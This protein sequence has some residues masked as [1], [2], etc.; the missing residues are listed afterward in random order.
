MT[1][2]SVSRR[3]FVKSAAGCAAAA[4]GLA[5]AAPGMA[6]A[7]ES[8]ELVAS[9]V[10]EAQVVIIGAGISGLSAAVQCAQNGLGTL[11]LERAETTGGNGLYA[12]GIFA[13]G[14][15]P[16][17]ESGVEFDTGALIRSVMKDAQNRVDGS[18]WTDLLEATPANYDWMVEN[19]V[20][21]DGLTNEYIPIPDPTMLWFKDSLAGVGYVPAMEETARSN[22]AEF[23]F[24]ARAEQLIMQDGKAV[25]VYA[26]LA[27]DS[28]LQVNAD[29]V[30]IA[31]GG[32]AE[33][34][35]LYK[36]AGWNVEH[37]LYT[38]LPGH[39]GDGY[40][41]AIAAGARSAI[42]DTASMNRLH[43]DG[44]PFYGT[45]TMGLTFGG[46][47]L[48]VNSYGRRF[49]D[50][51]FSA[52]NATSL[53][54]AVNSTKALWSI[55][56]QKIVNMA[57]NVD[58]LADVGE[59]TADPRDEIAAAIEACPSNNIFT[60]DTFEELA[61]KCGLPADTLLA[62]I[63][64][65]NALCA[66][67]NDDQFGKDPSMMI[68]IDEPPYYIYRLDITYI[69]SIGALDTDHNMQVV[70]TDGDPIDGLYAIGVDGVRLYRN[71]YPFIGLVG[72][73]TCVAH[74]VNSGRVAANNIASQLA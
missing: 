65:Y 48:W 49:I 73:G 13:V 45:A 64:S 54:F 74:C 14:S 5:L 59:I 29:A 6:L 46:P 60:A 18:L 66:A 67:G 28:I 24:G 2:N 12:N 72:G 15:T 8:A 10:K 37:A 11:V 3:S 20:T 51:N 42:K 16:H 38:G 40:R 39:T 25:G 68:P 33:N 4:T 31:T 63:E 7:E 71:V 27:D 34:M 47:F 61:Q 21:F 70:N 26:R 69:V 55:A 62:S 56:D 30:I 23:V 32:F 41:M 1:V 57:L 52:D 43:I 19:G 58:G 44:M 9:E 35:E 17:I 36:E 50:E 53:P 22:G